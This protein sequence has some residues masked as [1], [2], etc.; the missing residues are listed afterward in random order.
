[1]TCDDT[2]GLI[3][4]L[5]GGRLDAA[6]ETELRDHAN[7]C[8]ECATALGEAD[9]MA[10]GLSSS[11]RAA[12]E[13]APTDMP[14]RIMRAVAS[15]AGR[16][17]IPAPYAGTRRI[18]WIGVAATA[19]A[20]AAVA[21]ALSIP[22]VPA[23]DD[24]TP[25]KPRVVTRSHDAIRSQ[26]T[27]PAPGA[28][29]AI[30]TLAAGRLEVRPAGSND[31]DVIETGAGL[32]SGDA[33]RASGDEPCEL[34][35][36]EGSRIFLRPGA[37]AVLAPAGGS[38]RSIHLDTGSVFA[39]IEK[40][41]EAFVVAT[42]LGEVTTL[43][44]RFGVSL[45]AGEG[46]KP[47][48]AVAVE[49]GAVRVE[50]KGSERVVRAGEGFAFGG[51]RGQC[52]MS[53]EQCRRRF[54]WMERHLERCGRGGGGRG[55]CSQGNGRGHEGHDRRQGGPDAE[56]RG[57]GQGHGAGHAAEEKRRTE[58][59]QGGGERL[60]STAKQRAEEQRRVHE[61][62]RAE[63]RKRTEERARAKARGR[64]EEQRRAAEKKRVK[65]QKRVEEQNRVEEQRRIEEELK[66]EER[67]RD[68]A[69]QGSGGRGRGGGGGGGGRGSGG[70]GGGGGGG[71]RGR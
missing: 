71:R 47:E 51:G 55:R 70:G 33:L 34:L 57:R 66:E 25:P 58:A 63:E 17:G 45:E 3:D 28:S 49:E 60:R 23:P 46:G 6:R 15:A 32:R 29:V 10:A 19:A 53:G 14:G 36:A 8:P 18:V 62:R 26:D 37:E 24:A 68:E 5:L 54:G 40:D 9:V 7:V 35:L 64:A 13:A 48:L 1:M 2:H 52:G 4:E 43:G 16:E 61:R 69:G 42:A 21:I 39:E 56:T 11:F 27:A 12:L 38:A 41:A 20:A 50:S 59:G 65:E 22:A 44:T 31:Y 30:A 67:R